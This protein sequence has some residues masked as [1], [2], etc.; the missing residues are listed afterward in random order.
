MRKRAED[1]NPFR[2][3]ERKMNRRNLINVTVVVLF[4]CVFLSVGNIV[5]GKDTRAFPNIVLILADDMGYGEP[6]HAGGLIPTPALDQLAAEGLRFTDAHTSSSVCT[7]TRY[8][9]LTGRYN[10]RSRLKRGVLIQ[11]NAKALMDPKRLS[12]AGFLQE[13]GYHTGMVGKWHLGADW[14]VSTEKSVHDVGKNFSSWK[15]DYSKPFR[16]GPLDHGFDQAF[17]ILSS[18]DMPPY[19]YLEGDRALSIPSLNKSYPHNEYNDYHRTGAAAE[20]FEASECLAKWASRSRSYIKEQAADKEK[21]FFLYLPL[22][23]PHT[24]VTPGKLF[25]GKYKQY[26]WY[27]DFI[28]ETD[29]VVGQV[30]EE[31]KASGVDDNTLVIYTSD[32]GFATYV[33][34]PKMLAA[35]YKPSGDLRGAKTSIYEG[36]HR[37]PFLVRWPG[38]VKAGSQ[39]DS[40]VCTTDFYATFADILDKSADILPNA[41][42]DSFS[43]YPCMK[44]EHTEIR[45][46]I[47]HHSIGGKF[48]IRKGDW[49]LLLTAKENGWTIPSVKISAQGKAVQLY[50]LNADPSE[51]K[52]LEDLHPEKINELVSDL[53]KAFRDGRTTPGPMQ[54]N[55]GWP[56]QDDKMMKQFPQLSE[57]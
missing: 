43:F 29:W 11:V 44:G 27:A 48:A 39:S 53:A 40:V 33:E 28:A 55:E 31:L 30:L 41:A 5:F 57:N 13:Q 14:K 15:V 56:I 8:G 4:F 46:S 6:A 38:K 24:P 10:W 35:G 19:L 16:G 3:T 18:L 1:L 45:P 54:S 21:P 50:N 12:L 42:E 34:I 36:G 9:I 47:I 32:N 17:F 22:S 49:K 23:S 2:N 26:S 52:N 20:D 25:K 7:P 37:V 51:S